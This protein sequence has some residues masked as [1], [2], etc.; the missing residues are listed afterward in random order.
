MF[1]TDRL[2]DILLRWLEAPVV[3]QAAG[4]VAR[5]CRPGL[6]QHVRQRLVGMS[7]AQARGY[8][9]A[10][11]PGFVGHEVDA[12]LI[13]RRAGLHLHAQV[14][15]QAVEVLIDLVADDLA[16]AESLPEAAVAA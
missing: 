7:L 5:E 13:R 14:A 10:V 16:C 4:E 6:W 11:A 9:R 15:A 2:L 8:L 12:V 1:L 3:R